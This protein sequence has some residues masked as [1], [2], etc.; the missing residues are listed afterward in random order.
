MLKVSKLY[1]PYIN[2]NNNNNIVVPVPQGDQG[3][4]TATPADTK[5]PS[6]SVVNLSSM[7]MSAS[8][9]SLLSKGLNFC[10][11]PGEPNIS[12]LRKDLD[13]FHVGLRRKLFF[14]KRGGQTNSLDLSACPQ[15]S[16]TDFMFS[17]VPFQHPKFKNPSSWCPTAP[18][19]LESM[20]IFNENLLT[21]YI[22]RAPKVHNLTPPETQALTELKANKD[23]VIKPAD[24]G[25]AVVIQNKIDYIAEGL[26]Q[27]KDPKFY[28]EVDQD[29]TPN[30]NLQVKEF[31]QTLVHDQEISQE[32]ANYLF[33]EKP[34]TPQLYLLPK[35][36]KNKVPPPG[37]P[38]VSGNSSPT[39]RLSQLADLFLQPLVAST[40][41]YVRDTT[42]FINKI[43]NVSNLLPGSTLCTI[44]VTSLYTNIP[45]QE[46]INACKKML[47]THRAGNPK[48][49]N[50]NIANILHYVLTKNNF[51]FNSKHYLQVGGTAMGTKVAP[52]F[53][54]LFMADFE[55]KWVYSYH[56]RPSL[57]LR[58][59]DD[60]FMIWEHSPDELNK[61]LQHLNNCHQT[62]KFTAEQSTDCVNF[63]DTTVYLTP[64]G[65]LYTDLFCKPTDS[66][67]YLR[68]DSAHP[69][70]CKTSLPYSQLLRV[71]RICTKLEDFDRNALMLCS[72]FDRRG[73]P[74]DLIEESFIKVRRTDR[75]SLLKPPQTT[76]RTSDSDTQPENL[77]LISDY[78]PG[79]S[80]LR[81][82]VTQNWSA[83]GRTNTT[84]TLHSMKVIFGHRRN[85]NLRD[86]LVHSKIESGPPQTRVS[87]DDPPNALHKC[88]TKRCNYCPLL[89]RS[90]KITSTTTGR[91]YTSRK[92][93]S[94]KSHN[95]I[96]CI[97]CTICNKQYVGQTKNRLMDRFVMHFGNI[98][99]KNQKDPIGRHFSSTGHDGQVKI[100]I[101]I[102][103]FIHAPS[104]SKPGQQLRDDLEKKWIHR[105]QSLS[106]Q[107]INQAD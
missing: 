80:P 97:T 17:D 105:L 102:V 87:P 96:Y 36:H 94:C 56:T 51:D 62:I 103:D 6:G 54:N 86:I 64:E 13:K 98:K 24:K 43:Q 78:T 31:I 58:Y 85:K 23:I 30:H 3:L 46:G 39:E 93:I 88:I 29:L 10:P 92:H 89:D 4:P 19:Q 50:D 41:S 21:E 82:I 59:I 20:I 107:G 69:R 33:I 7:N 44:D 67:N 8:V 90:G 2:L 14:S 79:A 84:E 73:Y 70:H 18:I 27:L 83:L 60:I 9:Q 48:P 63:L 49:S 37:R 76:T 57:W 72:H 11:T 26:K 106:P 5:L 34:R 100:K 42:D 15:D 68:Y 28:V 45:N 91:T 38:I 53:A 47:D 77:Y 65:S 61:F 16:E 52:S 81:N 101:H 99:R 75:D 74:A 66:H 12:N 1:V 95:L 40:P 35:I 71:R 25:S 32:C 22:P 104:N 55:E